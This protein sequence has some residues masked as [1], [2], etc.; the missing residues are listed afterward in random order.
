MT[1]ICYDARLR[2]RRPGSPACPD[3]RVEIIAEITVRIPG[4]WPNPKDRKTAA[5]RAAGEGFRKLGL[6]LV[7]DL[8]GARTDIEVY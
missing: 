5:H 7:M 4:E 3:H 6:G 2:I 8:P 1:D